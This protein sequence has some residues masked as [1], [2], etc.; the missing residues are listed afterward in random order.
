[1][2]GASDVVQEVKAGQAALGVV[3]V[4]AQVVAVDAGVL[5]AEVQAGEGVQTP[6]AQLAAV[7]D[8]DADGRDEAPFGLGRV[9]CPVLGRQLR[10]AYR[11]PHPEQE[12]AGA[13]DRA[14]VLLAVGAQHVLARDGVRDRLVAQQRERDPLRE[15]RELVQL[16]VVDLLLALGSRVAGEH[17]P[18]ALERVQLD[19]D[20]LLAAIVDGGEARLVRHF[21]LEHAPQVLRRIDLVRVGA[22]AARGA[23]RC[24]VGAA[25]AGAWPLGTGGVGPPKGMFVSPLP[26]RGGASAPVRSPAAREASPRAGGAASRPACTRT[27]AAR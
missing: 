27:S 3:D 26:A 13:V 16:G 23:Q 1:M 25:P 14:Q 24:S 15:L 21:V 18:A 10:E 4:A 11:R 17:R 19:G 8:L 5:G 2:P 20:A 6:G 22:A 7:A 9:A 12:V